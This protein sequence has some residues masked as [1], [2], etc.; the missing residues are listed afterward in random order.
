MGTP[1]QPRRDWRPW[2]SPSNE[3]LIRRPLSSCKKLCFMNKALENN[4]ET[5][6]DETNEPIEGLNDD[7]L[8]DT[9]LLSYRESPGMLISVSDN[10][11][12]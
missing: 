8:E 2:E 3:E 12:V 5:P 6:S 7:S 10:P 9:L 1:H 11:M 4:Q